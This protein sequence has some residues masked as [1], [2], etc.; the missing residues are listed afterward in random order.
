MSQSFIAIELPSF[1]ASQ[2][3]GFI[4][5]QLHSFLAS[6]LPSFLS[7]QLPCLLLVCLIPCLLACQLP[8][9]LASQLPGFLASQLPS[10]LASQLPSF[11]ASQ[12]PSSNLSKPPNPNINLLHLHCFMLKPSQ[13]LETFYRG[14]YLFATLQCCNQHRMGQAAAC[15]VR[16]TG[17]QI[18][19]GT[20]E[21]ERQR[22]LNEET[23]LP[24][25][26]H[27]GQIPGQADCRIR[28]SAFP[29]W[30]VV[31]NFANFLPNSGH[32]S[33]ME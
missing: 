23:R 19:R 12:F 22:P 10:F 24:P 31:F 7:S 28:C 29:G 18:S 32:F 17:S 9:F 2:L 21:Y 26:V 27:S 5:S 16:C 25:S 1:L 14:T 15:P 33:L 3:P 8:S 30:A 6:Q 13:W 11:L 20:N 4:A